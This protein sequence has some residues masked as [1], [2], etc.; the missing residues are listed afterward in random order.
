MGV[1]SKPQRQQRRLAVFKGTN[2]VPK[3][4]Q[5]GMRLRFPN[6][7]EPKTKTVTGAD[8]LPHTRTYWVPKHPTTLGK[9][10]ALPTTKKEQK[11][12]EKKYK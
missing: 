10:G 2:Y 11:H 6:R 9:T 12:K 5:G 4:E 8:G 3:T 1:D 7:F